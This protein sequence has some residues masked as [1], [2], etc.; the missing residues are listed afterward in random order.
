[1][2]SKVKAF[3]TLRRHYGLGWLSFR[4]GYT[5]RRSLGLLRLQMPAYR[6]KDHPLRDWLRPEIPSNVYGYAQ[7]RASN[8]PPFLLNNSPTPPQKIPWQPAAQ[9]AKAESLLAG[10]LIY[11]EHQSF[12]VGFPPDWTLD[13]RTGHHLEPTQHWT[14]IPDDG[15]D[16]IKYVWEPGRFSFIYT[17]VRAY[18]VTHDERFPAAFWQSVEDWMEKNPPNRGPH[19]MS[20]QEIALRLLA[21]SFGGYAFRSSP[22][23][24]PER[25]SRFSQA[26][27][28]MARRIDQNLAYAISTRSNHT[29]SEGFGLWLVGSLFPELKDA[30]TYQEKGRALLEREARAQIFPDGA[31]AMYSLNYQRFVMHLYCLAV[32]LAELQG[33]RF[34]AQVYSALAASAQH[35][36][37][38]IDLRTGEMPEFGSNDGALVLPLNNCDLNDFRPLLQLTG[39]LAG[40]KRLFPAGPW[41][42]DLF[43]LCGPDALA[44]PVNAPPQISRHFPDGGISILRAVDSQ[45]VA[46]CV[47]YRERPSQADQLHIDLRWHGTPIAIDAGTYLYHGQGAWQNGLART[48][49]HNTVTV[50]GQDQMQRLTRF[51][52]GSWAEGRTVQPPPP[53]LLWLGEHDGYARLPDPVMHRRAIAHLGEDGW[54]VLDRLVGKQPHQF[55]LHWLL[56]DLP[57]AV[58]SVVKTKNQILSLRGG[59]ALGADEATPNCINTHTVLLNLGGEKMQV[60]L[61]LLTGS[62]DFS[63]VRADPTSTRGWRSR[64]YG[65][66]EPALSL[67]L[68]TT[69]AETH[70]WTYLG[71]EKDLKI[72]QSALTCLFDSHLW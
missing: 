64:T 21:W 51:T 3:E 41:D 50:D 20:G 67:V 26:V 12:S 2:L 46:R 5:L 6:W 65:Q 52:W 63:I 59:E 22:H 55:R 29:I 28:A 14:Q 37:Q 11:F 60:R 45:I 36:Y 47:T 49:V 27:A 13:P 71:P 68:E 57:Y 25:L 38:L 42:E 32:R 40:G 18:A 43:W 54:L 69:Q 62:S 34:S 72:I 53:P 10:E 33:A 15:A 39:Y 30:H 56:S 70:F 31:Y 8:A 35:L 44:A 23:S 4:L 1:M 17:L 66:K 24:T 9:V 16:D 19:W 48:D 7:W 58:E 61:G